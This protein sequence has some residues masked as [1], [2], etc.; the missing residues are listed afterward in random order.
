MKRK[1]RRK[2]KKEREEDYDKLRAKIKIGPPWLTR[3]ERA[4]IVGIRALQINMGAPVLI[5]VT[6]FDKKIREDPVLIA[7][8]ELEL[9]ILPLTIV[10][11]TRGGE[12]QAIPVRWLVELDKLRPRIH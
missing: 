9:G 11:Y 3:F 5:D 1:K 8:K 12:Y 6:L 10:R 7:E 4:R 2:E